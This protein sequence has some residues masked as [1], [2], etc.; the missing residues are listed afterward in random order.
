MS[1]DEADPELLELLRQA[2]RGNVTVPE[3]P[4]TKVLEGAEY[5]YNNSIDVAIDSQY[6]KAAAGMI[7]D[8]MQKQ[9]YST[10]M[11]SAHELHPKS[12]DER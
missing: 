11:W 10:K 9:E 5:V 2:L 3:F 12:K 7:Y 4:E 6:T 1:D 8:L